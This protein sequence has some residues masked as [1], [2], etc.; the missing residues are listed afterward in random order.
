MP[1]A[2]SSTSSGMLILM[3]LATL[4]TNS[5]APQLAASVAY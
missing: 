5:L 1:A 2:Q 4:E 3:L